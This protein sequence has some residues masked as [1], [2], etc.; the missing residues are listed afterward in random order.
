MYALRLALV[1]LF[2]AGPAVLSWL[3]GWE[4]DRGLEAFE[5]GDAPQELGGLIATGDT[6]LEKRVFDVIVPSA[7]LMRSYAGAG[8]QALAYV[9]FYTG[10][11]SS[12]AHDPEVCYPAQGFDIG[13]ISDLPLELA[14]GTRLWSKVFRARQGG[15]EELVVHWFQPRDRWPSHPR[16][17]PWVR[18][19]H[20]FRGRKAYAFVR[21]SVEIGNDGVAR[22]EERAIAIARELAPWSRRVLSRAQSVREKAAHPRPQEARDG[23]GQTLPERRDALEQRSPRVGFRA[24]REDLAS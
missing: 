20:A 4:G 24:A 16:L 15:Y 14:D 2:L 8:A 5:L 19:L 1:F 22:A 3:G 6:T 18:M 23:H 7:Y 21:V 13:A 10:F 11:T 9:A 17:E 12:G